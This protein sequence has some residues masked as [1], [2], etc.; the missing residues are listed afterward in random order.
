MLES[1]RFKTDR[2][3]ELQ[4]PWL[5]HR[6]EHPPLSAHHCTPLP[7]LPAIAAAPRR[8][9]GLTVCQYEATVGHC[10]ALARAVALDGRRT[11]S[12]TFPARLLTEGRVLH[13][14]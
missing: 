3:L 10:P 5:N 7:R 4:V 8:R 1:P 13:S 9:S 11:T 12:S 6:C 2:Y 14:D